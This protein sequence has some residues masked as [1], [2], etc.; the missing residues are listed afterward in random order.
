[1]IFE[2]YRK[3]KIIIHVLDVS[4]IEGRDPIEDFKKINSELKL[5]SENLLQPQVVACNKMDI[6]GAEKNFE[7][8]RLHLSSEGYDVF[9]FQEQL[10]GN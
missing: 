8:V 1:M 3:D 6:P 4:G 5:Y 2:T 10:N 7:R 9:L